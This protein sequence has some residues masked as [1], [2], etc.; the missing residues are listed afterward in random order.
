MVLLLL[1]AL[2]ALLDKM[3]G[4]LLP[5]MDKLLEFTQVLKTSM[6]KIFI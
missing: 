4:H 5:K 2:T 1:T 3:V 6:K